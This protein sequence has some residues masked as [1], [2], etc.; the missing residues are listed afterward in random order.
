MNPS[1]CGGHK[2]REETHAPIFSGWNRS[3]RLPAGSTTLALQRTATTESLLVAGAVK[4]A[5]TSPSDTAKT[6]HGYRN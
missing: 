3:C 2:V 5:E 1:A 6:I 4:P